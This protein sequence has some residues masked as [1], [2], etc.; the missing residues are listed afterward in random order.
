MSRVER[1]L[2]WALGALAVA[3]RLAH[4]LVIGPADESYLLF[5]ARRIL[6][7][8]VIYRD[9]FEVLM[10]LAFQFYA[11]VLAIGGRTLLAAR[12]AA[13]IVDGIGC[14]L[15]V[16]LARRIAGPAEATLAAVAFI[17]LA[18]PCFPHASP[19]WLSTTL[20]LATAAMMLSE[21]LR[22]SS[23][24]RPALAGALVGAAVCVQQQRGVYLAAWAVLAMVVLAFDRPP[25]ARL[26][27]AV[28]TVA[29]LTAGALL[30]AAVDLGQAVWASSL[31]QVVYSTF[32]FAF[33]NYGRVFATH[34]P[35]GE[36][37]FQFEAPTWL[38]LQRWGRLF[39]VIEAAALLL[40]ARRGFD[41][42]ERVRLCLLLLGVF[43]VLS[44]LYHPDYIKVGFVLPFLLIPGA[45]TLHTIFG[46]LRLRGAGRVRLV[47][48]AVVGVL[49]AATCVKGVRT[50]ERARSASPLRYATAFGTIAGNEANIRM[51]EAVRAAVE[52][53]PPGERWLYSYPDD[54]WLY[55][56]TGARDPTR[57]SLLLPWY[58]S[59]AQVA[60]AIADVHRR[61]PGTLVVDVMYA[62]EDDG[63]RQALERDYDLLEEALVLR[64]YRRRR[65]TGPP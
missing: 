29:W 55:L 12:V 37:I 54:A 47:R 56:A 62:H 19:H 9:F 60:E 16:V 39:L 36:H 40:A 32:T 1:A 31:S 49:V 3:Y 15:L 65:D 46:M 24:L 34:P 4:P 27:H 10:P 7:G 45:R 52:R 50:L 25:G 64:V 6:D 18:L 61:K 38:W 17:M 21:R 14:G 63:V 43:A 48:Y 23:R 42:L 26:R 51:F 30:I 5:G 8:E 57:F 59:P 58:N 13:A 53:D 22:E 35:W 33:E 44:I 2:P 20:W 11:A 28:S 41:R